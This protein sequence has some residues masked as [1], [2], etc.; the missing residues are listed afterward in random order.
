[1]R[2]PRWILV[3]CLSRKGSYDLAQA[4]ED[5]LLTA[6]KVVDEAALPSGDLGKG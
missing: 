2:E 4:P 3:G 5:C 6:V 1:M